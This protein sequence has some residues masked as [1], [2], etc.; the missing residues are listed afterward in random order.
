[1]KKKLLVVSVLMFSS[2]A[3]AASNI[4]QGVQSISGT[5]RYSMLDPENGSSIRE[6]G[7]APKYLYFVSDN[8]GLGASLSYSHQDYTDSQYNSY[9]IGPFVRYYPQTKSQEVFPYLGIGY[10]YSRLKVS[11]NFTPDYEVKTGVSSVGLGMDY[12]FAENIALEAEMRYSSTHVENDN[13]Q[14]VLTTDSNQ[15]SLNIGINVFF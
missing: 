14:V 7:I 5:V 12:F 2:N 3:F 8:L 15:S 6:Y 13:N 1:M 4:V 11:G 10:T 9:G